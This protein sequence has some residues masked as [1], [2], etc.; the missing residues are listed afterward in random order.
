MDHATALGRFALEVFPGEP[1]PRSYDRVVELHVSDA[2]KRELHS[3]LD[4]LQKRRSVE[5]AGYS[6]RPVGAN[7]R[8]GGPPDGARV[9]RGQ[10]VVAAGSPGPGSP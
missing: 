3:P 8:K 7:S 9:G 10:R 2:G 1:A 4:R 5:I 6:D